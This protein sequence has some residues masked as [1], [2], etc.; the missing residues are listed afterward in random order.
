M[1]ARRRPFPEVTHV[2]T[3]ESI[4]QYA[5][6]SGDY[7]PLHVDPEYGA[8]SRFG[9]VVAHGPL[10]LQALFE[11]TT[12]WLEVDGL[13]AGVSI[14]AAYR[15]PVRPGDAVTARLDEVLDHAGTMVLSAT[16][17]N[18]RGETVIEALVSVPRHLAP[19]AEA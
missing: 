12:A 5:E 19:R 2:V 15:A 13:P 8:A 17:S 10:G 4:L 18:Q 1:T 3:D 6:V 7:N 14:D 11:A 9:S 16:C